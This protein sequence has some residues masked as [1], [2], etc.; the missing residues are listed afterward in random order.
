MKSGSRATDSPVISLTSDNSS[1]VP[2]EPSLG[3][4]KRRN[5]GHTL[6]DEDPKPV[7]KKQKIDLT[8][9]S[10]S[11][12]SRTKSIRSPQRISRE[13]IQE[14]EGDLAEVEGPDKV[15]RSPSPSRVDTGDSV[16]RIGPPRRRKK[17]ARLPSAAKLPSSHVP[18][19]PFTHLR[20][21]EEENTQEAT[22]IVPHPDSSPPTM[23]KKKRRLKPPSDVRPKLP[24][25]AE[26][27]S[28]VLPLPSRDATQEPQ[29]PPD[30]EEPFEADVLPPDQDNE[31]TEPLPKSTPPGSARKQTPP[32][33]P[34]DDD[35]PTPT[36]PRAK[37]N[38]K[39]LGPVPRLESSHF[40]PYLRTADITSVIDEFS[41]KKTFPTQDTIEPSVQDSQVHRTATGPHQPSLDP[42]PV[43]DTLDADLAQKIQDV[44]DTYID[45]ND[46]AV[47]N[48]VPDQEQPTTVSNLG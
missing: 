34:V 13:T 11:Q 15:Y 25:L 44:Q 42:E 43:D 46:R 31:P 38:T 47:E 24:T 35:V 36:P 12:K 28:L 21:E 16:V 4:R 20:R 10:A 23:K 41:P 5:T 37:K 17:I 3:K 32:G 2:G 19:P 33:S 7:S 9:P 6:A 48:G 29:E 40:K 22:G 14:E 45:F 18:D 26:K 30:Q 39:R 27:K 1:Q 8:S